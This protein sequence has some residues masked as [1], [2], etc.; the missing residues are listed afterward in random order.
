MTLRQEL[1]LKAAHVDDNDL[2]R[3]MGYQL[4]KLHHPSSTK[5]FD[6]KRRP[7][8]ARAQVLF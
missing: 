1:V 5:M 4:P 8:G 7:A 6:L 2:L 3:L